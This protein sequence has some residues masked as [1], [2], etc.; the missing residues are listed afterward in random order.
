MFVVAG[1][2]PITPKPAEAA[3]GDPAARQD[4]E[5]LGARFALNDLQRPAEVLADVVDNA[6]VGTIGP[7]QLEPTPA[8][9][10]TPLVAVEERLQGQLAALGILHSGT[11]YDHHQQKTQGIDHNMPFAAIGLLVH[12]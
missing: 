10:D 5:A 1:Q 7:D 6:F 11:M 2:T 8:V 12:V 3:L 9:V 4:F